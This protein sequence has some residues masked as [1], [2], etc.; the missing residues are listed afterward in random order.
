MGKFYFI[1]YFAG[2]G[3]VVGAGVGVAAFY[4]TH[5]SNCGCL[6]YKRGHKFSTCKRNKF[7]FQYYKNK[8]KNC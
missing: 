5:Q 6:V 8:K 2:V 7:R 3:V 4:D 1:V